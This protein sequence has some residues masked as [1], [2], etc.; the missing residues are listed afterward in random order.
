V[1]ARFHPIHK[2]LNPAVQAHSASAAIA[3]VEEHETANPHLAADWRGLA[4]VAVSRTRS[5]AGFLNRRPVRPMP[6][7]VLSSPVNISGP[8]FL[9]R[10]QPHGRTPRPPKAGPPTP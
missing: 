4:S 5:A 7:R 1:P 9:T 6:S 10:R 2:P 3:H 8:P